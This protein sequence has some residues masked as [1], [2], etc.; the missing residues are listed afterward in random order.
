M[1]NTMNK[2]DVAASIAANLSHILGR[3]ASGV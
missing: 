2:P 3:E 1:C